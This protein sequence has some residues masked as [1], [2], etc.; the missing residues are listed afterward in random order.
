MTEV[1]EGVNPTRMELLNVKNRTVLAQKGYRLLKEK[2]DALIMEFFEVVDK[3]RGV[4]GELAQHVVKGS[5]DL[6][7]SESLM[8]VYE[9]EYLS[10]MAPSMPELTFRMDNIMGVK[11]PAISFPHTEERPRFYSI[12]SSSHKLNE[13]THEF[14][15]A[16][17]KIIQLVEREEKVR[18]LSKEIKKTKRRVNALEYIMMPRLKATERYIRMRLEEIERENFFRLKMVKK[19]KD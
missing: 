9:V 6:V 10:D 7:A 8:G 17:R 1:I 14:T 12:L 15:L 3:A 19:K 5:E 16:S 4:R 18:R 13:S 2:R 11:V